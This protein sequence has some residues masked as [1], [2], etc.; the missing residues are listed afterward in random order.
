MM[1]NVAKQIDDQR[2]YLASQASKRHEQ[3]RATWRKEQL[4]RRGHGARPGS[5][6]RRGA[7]GPL[8]EYSLH[9]N[10]ARS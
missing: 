1:R 8:L 4:R 5:A 6:R 3:R 9:L 10:R 2:E 7:G